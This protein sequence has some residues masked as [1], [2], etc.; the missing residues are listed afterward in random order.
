MLGQ[1]NPHLNPP[2]LF[3]R[4][5][6]PSS[7]PTSA[8]LCFLHSGRIISASPCA[9]SSTS[10]AESLPCLYFFFPQ[11]T[12]QRSCCVPAWCLNPK[13]LRAINTVKCKSKQWEKIPGPHPHSTGMSVQLPEQ[14]PPVWSPSS[15]MPM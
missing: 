15:V 14:Q 13:K 5:L 9:R 1:C 2:F 4:H 10:P 6:F 3:H 12:T 7:I 8:H 11:C